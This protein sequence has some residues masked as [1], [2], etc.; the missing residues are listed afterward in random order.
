[1][2][3]GS[4]RGPPDANS[5]VTIRAAEEVAALSLLRAA[6]GGRSAGGTNELAAAMRQLAGEISKGRY[7][8]VIYDAEPAETPGDP[9]RAE[10][11][12]AVTQALNTPTRA[13]LCALRAGG[14]RLGSEQVLTWQTGYPIAVDFRSGVPSYQP[15]RTTAALLEASALDCVLV[16]G[17]FRTL[18]AAVSARLAGLPLIVI[19]PN[20]SGL[21]PAEAIAIDTGRAGIHEGGTAFRL[22]DVP[23]PLTAVLPGP[24]TVAEVLAEV[25]RSAVGR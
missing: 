7:C 10:G 21:A 22:D 2:D 25:T 14:N 12:I 4:N 8:A 5:R 13:A 16:L 3:V 15:G 19:G 6:I 17:D 1:V 18:P 9:H 24:A 23:L 20:A 11:L